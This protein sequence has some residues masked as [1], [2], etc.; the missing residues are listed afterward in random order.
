MLWQGEQ[1]QVYPFP[2]KPAR[3][4]IRLRGYR[5]A[6]S[7]CHLEDSRLDESRFS[8]VKGIADNKLNRI[9]LTKT[10]F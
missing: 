3:V 8:K 2:V 5:I 7:P 10:G 6:A 1:S 4:A 9:V